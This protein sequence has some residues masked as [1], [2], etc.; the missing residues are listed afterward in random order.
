MSRSTGCFN[1]VTTIFVVFTVLVLLIVLGMIGKV[2]RPP[3]GLAPQTATLP[4]TIVLPTDTITP[5]PSITYT[6]SYTLTASRTFTPTNTPTATDTPTN[7]PTTTQT[8]SKTPI[9]SA[10]ATNTRTPTKTRTPTVTRTPS[11]TKPPTATRTA[12][13]IVTAT[14]PTAFRVQPGTPQF[15]AQFANPALGCNYQGIAGQ[16]FGQN[17]SDPL[18]GIQVNVTSPTGFNQTTVSGSNP[19]FGQAGWQVQVDAKPNNLT[20]TI[21]LRNPQGVPLSDKVNITFSGACNG[22]LALINFVQTRPF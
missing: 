1:L 8:P 19:Q 20:Y 13:P 15:T 6:P 17:G 18:P 2:I 12:T 5:L 7:T 4:E 21:E 11:R 3:A 16:V 9:P 14:Q 10:T 22:N